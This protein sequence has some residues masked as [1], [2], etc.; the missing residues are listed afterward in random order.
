MPPVI[1]VLIFAFLIRTASTALGT[2]LHVHFLHASVRET[3]AHKY[4][5]ELK[6]VTVTL[7][8]DRGTDHV[9]TNV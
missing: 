6:D 8:E 3:I 5:D 9:R 1:A 2:G 7:I 4:Q